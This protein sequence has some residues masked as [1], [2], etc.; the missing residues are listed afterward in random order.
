MFDGRCYPRFA[1]T[2]QA[3]CSSNTCTSYSMC[4]HFALFQLFFFRRRRRRRTLSVSLS[5]SLSFS[6]L[7]E[8]DVVKTR[9]QAAQAEDVSRQAASSRN[10]LGGTE[11]CPHCVQQGRL[12]TTSARAPAPAAAAAAVAGFDGTATS[13]ARMALEA[14]GAASTT[15]PRGRIP[16]L[17]TGTVAALTHIARWEGPRGLYRGLDASLVMAIPSTVL[18]YTVYDDF[19]ARLERAGVG[20][21]AAPATAGSSARLLATVVMAPLELVRTRAQSHGAPE[22]KTAAGAGVAESALRG[23][24]AAS[25]SAGRGTGAGL[26]ADIPLVGSVGRDLAKVFRE[27]GVAALWRG[28][29]TTMWRD[30]P[31]SMVYWLGY[32]NLKAGLGCGRKVVEGGGGGGR[33]AIKLAEERASADF[34]LRSL[35]AGAISGV[36]ASLLTHPFDVV[37]TQRQVLVVGDGA[38]E[39]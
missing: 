23:A 8:S 12:F 19:L 34:L 25:G 38:G 20:N 7:S 14:G 30:V 33:V 15:T 3:T 24:K 6:A 13:A 26:L 18:Y 16:T 35:A 31:F 2:K 22:G 28:V 17:P 9:V 4:S 10:G 27:E 11:P 5:P 1:T 21:L 39:H 37:K 32:E 29:G 36:V